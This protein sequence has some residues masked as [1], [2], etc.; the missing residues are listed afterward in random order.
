MST[1]GAIARSHEIAPDVM[2]FRGVYHHWDSYPEGL[3]AT[4]YDLYHTV[5]NR[6]LDRMLRVLIDEHPAGWSTI[7]GADWTLPAGYRE[8]GELPCAVC[9]KSVAYHY[10]QYLG[11]L[12]GNPLG[13]PGI[14]DAT[15]NDMIQA[16]LGNYTRLGHPYQEPEVPKGP[17]C[18]CHGSRGEEGWKITDANASAAGVEYVYSFDVPHRQMYI[19]SS[20]RRDGV[21]MIGMFGTGDPDSTWHT[22]AAVDLEAPAP[23][24]TTLGE[25]ALAEG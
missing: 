3:G 15:P 9:G 10:R 23:D 22:M 20:Y 19:L 2:G 6:D 7:N 11:G 16:A 12:N 25:D 13:R 18:Y 17:E 24:W 1:R 8:R 4:L 14:P 21:K 5:F